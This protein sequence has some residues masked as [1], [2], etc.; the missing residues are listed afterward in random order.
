MWKALPSERRNRVRKGEK[1]GLTATWAGAEALDDFYHGVRGEHA[2]PRLA[3]PQPR[4][5]PG[6]AR[7][8]ARHRPRPAGARPR[9]ARRGRGRVPVLPGHD[10]G[11]RGCP[12]CGRPSR[13]VRTSSSTGRS[14]AT[15]AA[16]ATARS[17]S[18][19]R[20][21]T[22]G[23]SSSSASGAPS[24]TRCRGSSSTPGRARPPSVDRD[25]SRFDLLIRAWK[26]LP[27]PVA[28][29]LGPW[30]RRQVPN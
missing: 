26:R 29:A 1:L 7:R 5:L 6:D 24:P 20:S 15:A 19:A 11:A 4:L 17:T 30:I 13:S 8:A 22:R 28:N 2:R 27:M 10:H 9:R 16:R 18:A 21:G 23:R 14:S 3:G 12:R 25:A